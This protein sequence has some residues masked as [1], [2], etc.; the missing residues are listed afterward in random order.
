MFL[1]FWLWYKFVT[2]LVLFFN[3]SRLVSRELNVLVRKKRCTN[4][5]R[6]SAHVLDHA[7]LIAEERKKEASLERRIKNRYKRVSCSTDLIVLRTCHVEKDVLSV[8]LAQVQK[9]VGR[10]K[11]IN[12]PSFDKSFT[13]KVRVKSLLNYFL[14]Q[15]FIVAYERSPE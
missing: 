1:L 9:Q 10:M 15:Y 13:E 12:F 6:V 14:N 3:L 2:I 8:S 4:F 7:D 11:P 5:L